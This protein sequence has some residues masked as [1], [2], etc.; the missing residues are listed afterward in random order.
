MWAG[1]GSSMVHTSKEYIFITNDIILVIYVSR[2][3]F[4][5]NQ[6]E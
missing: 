2:K 6:N 3:V 5:E 4:F 1:L